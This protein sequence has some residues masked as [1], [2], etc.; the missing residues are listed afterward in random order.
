MAVSLARQCAPELVI[1][2]ADEAIAAEDAGKRVG[3]VESYRR[4]SGRLPWETESALKTVAD[5]DTTDASDRC[6]G[7]RGERGDDFN[8]QNL[9]DKNLES[10][11]GTIKADA[12]LEPCEGLELERKA[13]CPDQPDAHLVAGYGR[14]SGPPAWEREKLEH[15]LETGV[16]HD[17][18]EIGRPGSC[19]EARK[20]VQ[21]ANCSLAAGKGYSGFR[22]RSLPASAGEPDG[23]CGGIGRRR[24]GGV[25]RRVWPPDLLRS[26]PV[27]MPLPLASGEGGSGRSGSGTKL[28]SWRSRCG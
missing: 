17:S 3:Y 11:P 19:G 8:Y 24:P 15:P 2:D 26:G 10:S 9:E 6:I 23:H 16:S 7:L 5:L 18:D 12:T 4:R 22:T 13:A 14:V 27:G 28:I 21:A 25:C 1:V 20:L